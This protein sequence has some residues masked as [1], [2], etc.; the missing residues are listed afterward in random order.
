MS[1][2]DGRRKVIIKSDDKTWVFKAVDGSVIE[3]PE[4]ADEKR[5]NLFQA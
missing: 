3:K 1:F 4:E 5:R 2:I